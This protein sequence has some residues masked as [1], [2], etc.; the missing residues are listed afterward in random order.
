MGGPLHMLEHFYRNLRRAGFAEIY[1][2]VYE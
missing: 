1:K 2:E